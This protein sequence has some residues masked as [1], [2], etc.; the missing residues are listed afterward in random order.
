MNVNLQGDFGAFVGII[1][2]IAFAIVHI[3]FAVAVASDAGEL[4]NSAAGPLIVGPMLWVLATLLGGVF[5]AG[6]YWLVNHS[7]LSRRL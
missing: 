1:Y 4:Q 3:G 2:F 6:L 5:V 7:T